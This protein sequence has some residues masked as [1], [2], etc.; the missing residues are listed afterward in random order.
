MNSEDQWMRNVERDASP[1]RFQSS[2]APSSSAQPEQ[3]SP[4]P[5]TAKNATLSRS[6]TAQTSSSSASSVS[7]ISIQREEIG[8]SRMPTERDDAAGLER[9]A[10]ALSRIQ[11]GRS[12]QNFTVGA[13][14]RSRTV[15]RESKKPL[16]AFGGGKEYPPVLPE[17][18]AYVVEFDGPDDPLH[19]QNWPL[20]RKKMPVAVTLGFVTLTAAF[21]SSIFSAAIGSVA[22]QYG[23]SGEV[24]ILGVSLYVLGFATGPIVWAPLSE[25]YGRR[26]PL[27]ISS[28]GFSIFNIAVAV[29]KD[30]QTIFICRF[31]GGFFGAC[32]LTVVGAVFADML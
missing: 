29:G 21:G 32:P 19:A 16:P 28:F 25:L 24:G 15:T 2:T 14:L 4:P 11:T 23:I 26:Y 10:T 27:I 3:H 18:D 8:I 7:S 6:A 5:N 22:Q 1:E 13:G 12:Q 17:R 9:H 20:M 30:L 31:F